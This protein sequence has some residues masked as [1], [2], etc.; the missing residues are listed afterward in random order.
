MIEKK[1]EDSNFAYENEGYFEGTKASS[2]NSYTL[3]TVIDTGS[4]FETP[5]ETKPTELTLA[6]DNSTT[7]EV[8]Y[9]GQCELCPSYEYTN[10]AD[11]YSCLRYTCE[12]N[13]YVTT[14]GCV[15]CSDDYFV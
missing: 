14:S 6:C 1:T 5:V 13:E 9:Y 12:Y 2:V 11:I 7:Y 8:A 3:D 4:L 15:R 10:P